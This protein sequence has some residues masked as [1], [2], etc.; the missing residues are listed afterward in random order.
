MFQL[1]SV[2]SQKGKPI[3]FYI[4]KI[5]EAQ[6]KYIVTERELLK[7]VETLKEFRNISLGKILRIYT[8]NINFIC[9]FLTLI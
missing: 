1:G 8:D 4:G 3:V 2:I 7:I 6:R 9:E 5:I